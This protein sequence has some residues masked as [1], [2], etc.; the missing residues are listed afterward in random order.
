MPGVEI[1]G[2]K[3]RRGLAIADY[4]YLVLQRLG[5]GCSGTVY[6]PTDEVLARC[7]VLAREVV[8]CSAGRG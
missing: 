6:A 3:P 7:R 8:C 2:W 5:Q 4:G 1:D